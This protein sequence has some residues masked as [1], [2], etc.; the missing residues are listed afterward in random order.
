MTV[1]D[2]AGIRVE[3][4][5]KWTTLIQNA[6][7][8]LQEVALIAAPLLSFAMRLAAKAAICFTVTIVLAIFFMA[9]MAYQETATCSPLVCS[10]HTQSYLV[11]QSLGCKT[12]GIGTIYSPQ[13]FGL[14]FGCNPNEYSFPTGGSLH[15]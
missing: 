5:Y 1:P 10:V 6:S 8:A 9:P 11:F 4:E 12:I 13:W 15:Y 7:L 14:G 3:G 2:R